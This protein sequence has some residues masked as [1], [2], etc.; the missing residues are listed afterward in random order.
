ME[1]VYAKNIDVTS[2]TRILDI[3]CQGDLKTQIFHS[4]DN[5]FFIL[6][7]TKLYKLKYIKSVIDI[8]CMLGFEYST[9]DIEEDEIENLYSLI[10]PDINMSINVVY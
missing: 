1:F 6:E 10:N 9:I 2:F 7:G 5:E 3:K 8:I 4:S